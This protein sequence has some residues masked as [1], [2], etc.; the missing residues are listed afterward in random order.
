MNEK[1]AGKGKASPNGHAGLYPYKIAR[2]Y[3]TINQAIF[4]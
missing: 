3:K 4:H 1:S 2:F